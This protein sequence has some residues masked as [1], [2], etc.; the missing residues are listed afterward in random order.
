MP[1]VHQEVHVGL[2]EFLGARLETE[3]PFVPRQLRARSLQRRER[4]LEL[5]VRLIP[6]LGLG[7]DRAELGVGLPNCL[8][9]L[10][11]GGRGDDSPKSL[12]CRGELTS[13]RL[14]LRLSEQ[15]PQLQTSISDL[16]AQRQ[17]LPVVSLRPDDVSGTEGHLG[18]AFQAPSRGSR[19]SDLARQ[20]QRLLV[21]GGRLRDVA[22]AVVSLVAQRPEANL[23]VVRIADLTE[24]VGSAGE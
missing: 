13:R 9:V 21:V 12:L 2:V 5:Q 16:P 3:F 23:P 1:P 24:Q 19:F 8:P 11:V 7:I 22:T 18:H 14:N 15:S 17:R 20:R 6:A 10:K 4:G